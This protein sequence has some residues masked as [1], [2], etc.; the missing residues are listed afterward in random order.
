MLSI[1]E[2]CLYY[3]FLDSQFTHTF[4]RYSIIFIDYQ[5]CSSIIVQ[6][7]SLGYHYCEGKLWALCVS[8]VLP[9][10]GV[11]YCTEIF[12]ALSLR[13]ASVKICLLWGNF[14]GRGDDFLVNGVG[15]KLFLYIFNDS[16]RFLYIIS[17]YY[18][19]DQVLISHCLLFL[20][21]KN[22]LVWVFRWVGDTNRNVCMAE[23]VVYGACMWQDETCMGGCVRKFCVFR[24]V[25]VCV[26]WRICVY[27]WYAGSVW[28]AESVRHAGA[29]EV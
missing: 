7:R 17:I 16:S 9:L 25:C 23:C 27:V 11:D 28:H 12:I 10:R 18:I 15:T 14:V 24:C 22:Y 5:S 2:R 19:L 13:V 20:T 1:L 6:L 26:V 4:L 21:Y 29:L 3:G 8:L